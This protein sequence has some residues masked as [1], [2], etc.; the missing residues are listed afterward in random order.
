MSDKV[1]IYTDGACSGN[2]GVGGWGVVMLYKDHK[3]TLYGSKEHTTNNCMELIAVIEAL[4]MMKKS[5]PIDLYTDS[6]Y[7]SDGV[8]KWLPNWKKNN[9]K[10]SNKKPVLNSEIWKELDEYLQ[11]FSVNWYW[12]K[13]H[14]GH[15]YNEETDLLARE[16]IRLHKLNK[17]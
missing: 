16:A 3:K 11:I 15:C 10:K 14:A 17:R 13:G 6:K 2:P 12:I 1:K 4:K 9:W 5:I 7:V 8:T